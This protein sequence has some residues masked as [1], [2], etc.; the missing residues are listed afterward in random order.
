MHWG[1]VYGLA[2]L[3]AAGLART[4]PKRDVRSFSL[5]LL[6]YWLIFNLIDHALPMLSD[7]V[8]FSALMDAVGMSL[9]LNACLQR[10]RRWKAL[11]TACFAAQL[12]T[13]IAVMFLPDSP[14]AQ[15]QY[16]LILNLLFAAELLSVSAP[17]AG[18]HLRQLRGFMARGKGGGG[19][20]SLEVEQVRPST[21]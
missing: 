15:Y 14:G 3:F 13:H 16:K 21:G 8:Q 12:A 10:M 19:R 7:A 17:T 18:F 5:L 9:A 2:A 6:L 11:L 4:G 20:A 1:A